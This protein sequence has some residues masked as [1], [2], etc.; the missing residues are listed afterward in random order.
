MKPK[1]LPLIVIKHLVITSVMFM[2]AYPD[3]QGISDE[4]SPRE[5]VLCWQ[6][7]FKTHCRAQFGAYCIV[8]NEPDATTTNTM[9]LRTRN[10]ICLGPTGNF[11]G[12]F[13]FLDLDT[14]TVIK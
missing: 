7:D 1:I 3:P 6:L 5:I 11:Q 14:L 4:F 8:Y 13:K 10:G 9:N 12:T 2:N